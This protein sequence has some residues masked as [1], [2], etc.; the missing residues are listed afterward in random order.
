MLSSMEGKAGS[1]EDAADAIKKRAPS[2]AAGEAPLAA[3]DE[4]AGEAAPLAAAV[5]RAGELTFAV[6]PAAAKRA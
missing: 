5:E 4:R 2:E 1:G 6:L 3:R